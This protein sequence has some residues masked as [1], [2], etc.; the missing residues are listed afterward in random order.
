MSVGGSVEGWHSGESPSALVVMG[1][2]WSARLGDACAHSSFAEG[3]EW[4][5]NGV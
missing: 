4:G 2:R 5:G 3:G 1:Y